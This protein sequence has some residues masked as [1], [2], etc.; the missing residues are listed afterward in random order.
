MWVWGY[1]Q[2]LCV[3]SNRECTCL[4]VFPYNIRLPQLLETPLTNV[5]I[6][7]GRAYVESRL[8]NLMGTCIE[9]SHGIAIDDAKEEHVL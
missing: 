6:E 7:M 4:F 8:D 3:T 9:N 2:Y 1:L 5:S